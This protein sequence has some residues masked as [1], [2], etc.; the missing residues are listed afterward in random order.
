ML[1]NRR[2]EISISTFICPLVYAFVVGSDVEFLT[3]ALS[4]RAVEKEWKRMHR[5]KAVGEESEEARR[6]EQVGRGTKKGHQVVAPAPLCLCT[7]VGSR[8]SL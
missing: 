7:F 3:V 1:H 6:I 4:A 2:K 5:G 8:L